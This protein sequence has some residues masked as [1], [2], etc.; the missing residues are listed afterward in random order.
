[1]YDVFLAYAKS[2]RDFAE[3]LKDK[4]IRSGITIFDPWTDILG[5]ENFWNA[6]T[7]GCL[8]AH[9]FTLVFSRDYFECATSQ[10]ICNIALQKNM[11][12]FPLILER[13]VLS[14]EQA[15]APFDSDELQL[16]ENIFQYGDINDI[17]ASNQNY[18]RNINWIFLQT[19]DNTLSG[20]VEEAAERVNE[21]VEIYIPQ[22]SSEFLNELSLRSQMW[23]WSG[24]KPS[25]LLTK[26]ELKQYE[27]EIEKYK[28]SD[29]YWGIL[30]D[31]QTYI[32][33]SS[34]NNKSNV[35]NKI[36]ISYRRSDTNHLVDELYDELVQEFGKTYVFYDIDTIELGV[37]FEDF[38]LRT[39]PDC[40]AVL[41]LM[42]PSWLST[43]QER[44]KQSEIDYVRLE[45]EIALKYPHLHVIP[46]LVDNASFPALKD[47]PASLQPLTNRNGYTIQPDKWLLGIN[48]LIKQ[49]KS[50]SGYQAGR[51]S[52]LINLI[53]SFFRL[54]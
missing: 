27:L 40:F 11:T 29:I 43:L 41:V 22:R 3:P 16:P 13:F 6:I 28:S 34:I 49:I 44:S 52:N 37:D 14:D 7:R 32:Y 4:L 9:S 15:M 35:A 12:F 8:T 36:F 26:T 38:I 2:N 30:E 53:S 45:V 18:M 33:A 50:T 31:T 10:L 54:K 46:V 25:L 23:E 17:R 19:N 24:H 39:L 20:R 5:H 48:D 51:Q 47:L 21:L 42:G 1:M